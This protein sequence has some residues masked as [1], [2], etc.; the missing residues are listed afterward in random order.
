MQ[1]DTRGTV[2]ILVPKR[3]CPHFGSPF[4]F[5]AGP[6]SFYGERIDTLVT[7][8]RGQETHEVIGSLIKGV[9]MFLQKVLERSPGFN[10]EIRDGRMKLTHLF[11][12]RLWTEEMDPNTLP[13]I[14][15]QKLRQK[16]EETGAEVEVGELALV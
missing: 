12:A 4:E 3:D 15:Y 10:F 5:I 2:P 6:D 13:G 14:T 11:T 16:A 9:R 8:Y 1:D 7:V